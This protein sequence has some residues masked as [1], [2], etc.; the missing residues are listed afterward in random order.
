MEYRVISIGTLAAH[1]LWG[2]ER[3]AVRTG[4]ATSTLVSTRSAQILVDPSLPTPAMLAR[5]GERSPVRA[6]QITDVFLTT[7]ELDH[8]RA[9]AAFPDARW[10]V[11]ETELTDARTE[12]TRRLDEA[13]SGG[14]EELTAFLAD[15]LE[16]LG[17]CRPAPDRLTDGVDLFPLPGVTPGCCGLLLSLPRATVL[18]CGDAIA[19]TEHL[20]Q[21]KVLP[22]CHDVELAQESFAEAIEIADLLILGRDNISLNPLRQPH[23]L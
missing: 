2:E 6:D 14:D 8:R 5:L 21:G 3:G 9:M 1:P 20:I 19:T 15:D 17:R 23:T 12:L 13:R 7:A 16:L 22:T 4:H 18:V 11:G 10:Y